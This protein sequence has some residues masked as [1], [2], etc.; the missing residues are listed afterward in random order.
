MEEAV[1]RFSREM[2]DSTDR[3]VGTSKVFLEAGLPCRLQECNFGNLVTDAI[4]FSVRI[5]ILF[6]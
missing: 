5:C 3:K 2:G 1:E 6:A 4:V